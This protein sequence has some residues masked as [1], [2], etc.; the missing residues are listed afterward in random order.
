VTFIPSFQLCLLSLKPLCLKEMRTL[1]GSDYELIPS[2]GFKLRV[3]N[4]MFGASFVCYSNPN[5]THD[6][7]WLKL[8]RDYGTVTRML[9]LKK[10][11]VY[12]ISRCLIITRD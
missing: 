2:E 8:E 12:L 9:V 6:K 4:E 11:S 1:S 7:L 10:F 5:S 3:S